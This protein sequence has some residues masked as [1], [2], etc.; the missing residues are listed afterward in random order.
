QA[1]HNRLSPERRR[2]ELGQW[3][4]RSTDGG[5]TWSARLPSIVNSPHG[6]IQLRDGRLLYA[7]KQLWTRPKRN[8]VCES[9]DDG[10]TSRWLAEIPTRPG[11][12]KAEYHELHAVETQGGR[13]LAQI[14][15]HNATN[16]GET[17]Q[18]ES[19]DAGKTWSEPH[20]IG[21]WGLP[22]HLLNLRDG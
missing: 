5:L 6:P 15:N 19:D 13:L 21:V 12:N 16:A 7:G 14:R 11:D 1:V 20:P 17:L 8:G 22:S 18:S 10:H 9:L 3:I 4:I 2:A